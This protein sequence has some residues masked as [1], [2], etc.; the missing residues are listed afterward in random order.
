MSYYC[1]TMSMYGGCYAQEML[2]E[3][4]YDTRKN[5]EKAGVERRDER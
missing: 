2:P 1:I 5:E 4:I 3:C